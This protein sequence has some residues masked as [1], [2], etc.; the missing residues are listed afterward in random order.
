[1]KL[2]FMRH[3]KAAHTKGADAQRPLTEEG[4]QDVAE[5]VDSR[6]ESLSDVALILTSPYR[7][8]R[9][10]A[11]IVI[12]RVNRRGAERNEQGF[13]GELLICDVLVPESNFA[14]LAKLLNELD[15]PSILLATHQPLIGQLLNTLVG[16]PQLQAMEPAWLAAVESEAVTPGYGKL[17][18]LEMPD[19]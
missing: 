7:R 14:A 2:Y 9:E 8:A 18:W 15:A 19:S 4:R 13:Q 1:M 10:T 12:E 3:G 6:I 17:L 16:D 11:D 5:V